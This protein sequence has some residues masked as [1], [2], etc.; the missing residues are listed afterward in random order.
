MSVPL[1]L[2]QGDKSDLNLKASLYY[3]GFFSGLLAFLQI[4]HLIHIKYIYFS[5]TECIHEELLVIRS[6]LY[7]DTHFQTA[8]LITLI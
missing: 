8:L 4:I 1:L 7:F 3:S 6:Q 5:N 2:Q